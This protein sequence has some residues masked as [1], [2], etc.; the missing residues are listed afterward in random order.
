MHSGDSES[1]D[2][3]DLGRVS[4]ETRGP[5]MPNSEVGIGRAPFGITED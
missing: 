3:I 4:E 2:L 5:D 1:D